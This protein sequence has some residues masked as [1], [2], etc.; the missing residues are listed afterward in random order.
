MPAGSPLPVDSRAPVLLG[1]LGVIP[2]PQVGEFYRVALPD[3]LRGEIT[4]LVECAADGFP[5]EHYCRFV[6]PKS[7]PEP[8]TFSTLE[9]SPDP[10]GL[11]VGPWP[12]WRD[13]PQM[14][15]LGIRYGSA[16]AEVRETFWGDEIRCSV[17][18]FIARIECD[19]TGELLLSTPDPLIIPK[20]AILYRT[21]AIKAADRDV[22]LRADLWGVH[23]RLLFPPAALPSLRVK[24]RGSHRKIWDS[25]TAVMGSWALP[26]DKTAESKTV[27]GSE[28]LSLED[29]VMLAAFVA[30][31]SPDEE[32]VRRARQAYSSYLT[33]TARSDFEPLR[34]DT[35]AGEVLFTLSLAYD[36]LESFMPPDERSAA[37]QRM[38]EVADVCSAYLGHNRRDYGQAHYLGCG[39]GLLAFSFV[40]W[41][42]H[43]QAK[44]RAGWLRGSLASAL[45]L[46]P[47]DGY[48]PHGINL[49]IYEFGFLL[50]WI[51][52]LRVCTGEDLW[53]A[54]PGLANASHFRAATIS[55][56]GLS[57]ITF[58]DPQ[59]R[60]GGDSWCHFLIAART[61]SR[62]AQW[63]GA[64]LED[65]PHA[66][67]DFRNVPARRRLYE[68]LFFDPSIE[69]R[70]PV[71]EISHFADGG[72]VCVRS[73]TSVFTL[74]SGPPLGMHRYAQGE[75]GA[76]GHSDPANG[77]FLL[78][79]GRSFIANGSGPVYRRDTRLHNLVTI[80]GQGQIGDSTVWLPDFIP[81]GMLAQCPDVRC[82]NTTVD[83]SVDLTSAYLR[84]LG[85][86]SYRRA[87]CVASDLFVAG[88]DIIR[89]DA[90]RSIEWNAHSWG[91]FV[92]IPSANPICYSLQ[93]GIR[94][95]L[96]A[97]AS[98][99]WSSAPT[100]F[101]PAYPN[102]GRRDHHLVGRVH[103]SEARFVWCYA[104]V[105]DIHPRFGDGAEGAFHLK[106]TDRITAVF[107]GHWLSCEGPT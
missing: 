32:N 5:F 75:Y 13:I 72:Q 55:P 50:R 51:E 31:I 67:V 2:P 42:D 107:D 8:N 37:M 4:I 81:P 100:A 62:E 94:L 99:S 24:A 17:L 22:S 68:F 59:Y 12:G 80:D 47:A 69:P 73:A 54:T 92:R 76:Y 48:Y 11:R 23:P 26:F 101:I 14:P 10:D 41:E 79:L 84:N 91:E 74:R 34:I 63:L 6:R 53:Q 18:R 105:P 78:F 104:L 43:A 57:G 28:R 29:R 20:R 3:T 95:V 82:R 64:L 35:Q 103:S 61:G 85:V 49:W 36:W 45:Q 15:V 38:K 65:L 97:P 87:V 60:V 52:I 1:T 30:L 86:Q 90:P 102:E 25:I 46:V 98:V 71:Q 88:V 7:S 96:V 19:G 89:C 83:I 58:G 93:E 40:S 33:E 39:L 106:I 16:D 70:A 27:E 56:D 9:F 44:V 21:V 77:S 66:G